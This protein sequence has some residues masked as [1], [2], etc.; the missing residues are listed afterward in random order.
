MMMST[1]GS[2][3]STWGVNLSAVLRCTLIPDTLQHSEDG[4]HTWSLHRWMIAIT[5]L[6]YRRRLSDSAMVAMLM[7]ISLD[8]ILPEIKVLGGSGQDTL[9][10]G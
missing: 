1:L 6:E 7:A 3:C 4:L 2:V 10:L 5:V 9:L 8:E